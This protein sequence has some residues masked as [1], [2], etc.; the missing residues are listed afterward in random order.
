MFYRS[1][2]WTRARTHT[3]ASSKKSVMYI[4]IYMYTY[5]C[6]NRYRYTYTYMD[7]GR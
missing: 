3:V 4:C 6:I 2:G 5:I 1:Y 7:I